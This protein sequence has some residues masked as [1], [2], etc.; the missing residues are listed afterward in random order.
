MDVKQLLDKEVKYRNKIDEISYNKPDPLL[1]AKK[2]NNEYISLICALFSYGKAQKI[3]EFL[4]SLDFDNM[5]DDKY[6]RF[7]T[8][9]DI[10]NLFITIN[11]LKQIDSIENIVYEGYKKEHNILD[12]L[13]NLIATLQKLNDYN[14]YGYR[15]LIGQPLTKDKNAHIKLIGQSAYKRYNMFFRWMVR[16]DNIDMGL[17]NKIDKKDLLI[18]LDTHTHKISLKLNLIQRKSYD[19]KTV[20]LLTQKLKQ[21]DPNDP[22]KYDFALYRIGQEMIIKP[23]LC[24]KNL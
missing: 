15:F 12:G 10:T 22:I 14:S 2:Y 24:I 7:Q 4:D 16:D 18:P 19:L 23:K 21:F 3:V 13:D 11:R 5:N 6:Y 8:P 20:V 1:I 17:W 9:Q